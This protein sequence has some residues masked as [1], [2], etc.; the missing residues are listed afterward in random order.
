MMSRVRPE[1]ADACLHIAWLTPMPSDDGG[2]TGVATD[3]LD[4]LCA[5]GHRIDCFIAGEQS[6]VPPRLAT[7]PNL[8]F[9][10]AGSRWRWNRW[11]SRSGLSAFLSGLLARTWAFVRMRSE[12]VRRD[13][14]DPYDLIYQFSNIETVGVPRRL[15]GRIPLVIHPETHIAGELRCF[16]HERHLARV[17]EPWHRRLLVEAMLIGRAVVQ[18]RAIRSAR[19]VLCIS[20]VF[21]DHLVAD[22]GVARERTRVIPNPV[23]LERF[24]A[25]ARSTGD[26]PVILVLGRI[27]VRKGVEHIV[28]LSRVLAARGLNVKLRIVGAKTL[29]SDYRVLLGNLDRTTAEYAGPVA[30]WQVP[31][32]LARSDVLVQA[33]TYEPFGLTVAEALA[34][35]VPVIATSEVGAAENVSPAVAHLVPVGAVEMLADAIERALGALREDAHALRA[36]ARSESERL[37]RAETVCEAISDALT[38]LVGRR[39]AGCEA[40]CVDLRVAA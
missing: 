32:E 5:L 40:S 13:R 17:C 11:Y 6:D 22:Y 30:S 10:W 39:P 20:N 27:S 29:W 14:R 38:Q 12:I 16:R 7:H 33:S 4:G 15:L 21:R 18:R 1:Q 8:T 9:V 23:R 35:G 36:L 19:L 3:L 31:Q 24:Q 28:E 34:A 37:F 26:P 2:A 25:A